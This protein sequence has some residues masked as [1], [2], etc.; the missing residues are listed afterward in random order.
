MMGEPS[1]DLR[2]SG[3]GI[4]YI[5]HPYHHDTVRTIDNKPTGIVKEIPAHLFLIACHELIVTFP[6]GGCLPIHVI[7]I[8]MVAENRQHT[9]G[10]FQARQFRYKRN[11]L[12][13]LTI[14][15]IAREDYQIRMQT[16]DRV[17][18]F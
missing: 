2:I 18:Q 8:V 11:H 4:P 14:H 12:L 13:C 15:K 7:T 6:V 9:V 1:Q 10:S 5:L 3:R 16:V 17:H